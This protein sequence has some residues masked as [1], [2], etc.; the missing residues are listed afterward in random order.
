MRRL[1]P[2]TLLSATDL[3]NFHECAH[4]TVLDLRALDDKALKAQKTQPDEHTELLFK[5]GN[6]FEAAYLADLKR[7]VQHADGTVVEIKKT[8]GNP[9]RSAAATLEALHS[10]ADLIYQGTFP[11]APAT[12]ASRLSMRLIHSQLTTRL[13]RRTLAGTETLD[14][15]MKN[16]ARNPLDRLR[17]RRSPFLAVHVSA[18]HGMH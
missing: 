17:A 9:A 15:R 6:E 10:G 18:A 13:V 8:R 4:L 5:R 7:Q 12:S 1:G 11:A 14:H 3:V 16:R 2:R